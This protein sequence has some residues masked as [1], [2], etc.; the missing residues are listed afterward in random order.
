MI[1]MMPSYM[2]VRTIPGQ[3]EFTLMLFGPSC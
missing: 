1:L 2:A 3:T